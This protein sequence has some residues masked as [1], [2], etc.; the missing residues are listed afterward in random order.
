M[1]THEETVMI[2]LEIFEDSDSLSTAVPFKKEK[3]ED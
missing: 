2:M 1:Y 3:D